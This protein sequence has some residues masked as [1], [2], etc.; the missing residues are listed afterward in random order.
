MQVKEL[1]S[2]VSRLGFETMLEDPTGFYHAVNRALMQLA[3]VSPEI[4]SVAV[5]HEPPRNLLGIKTDEAK[6]HTGG[7]DLIFTA[8]SGALA[9]SFECDGGAGFA[10]VETLKDGK[11]EPCADGIPLEAAGRG[12]FKT[13]RG[14]IKDEDGKP[15]STPMRLRFSGD[16]S[17]FVKNA[18]LWGELYSDEGN[19]VPLY[20]SFVKYDISD[21]TDDFLGFADPPVKAD[22]LLTSL[23]KGYRI[24]AGR[25]L[26]LPYGDRGV[27]EVQY[28]HKPS[29]V[30]YRSEPASAVDVLDVDEEYAH[31]LPLLVSAY[32]WLEDEPEKASYYMDLFRE[33][34]AEMRALKR[35]FSPTEWHTNGW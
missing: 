4:R 20:S 10:Y 31:L 32:V 24:E 25:R 17:F 29:T 18:A 34:V 3:S 13:Y 23:N 27:Y 33:R 21:L 16:Y 6:K 28:K 26:V 9:Y 5:L 1:Y 2:E 11:W 19:D 22:D 14:I 7:A 30:P 12:R 15:F 8:S 35:N